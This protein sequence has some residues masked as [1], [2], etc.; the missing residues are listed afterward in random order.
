MEFLIDC[1]L[2]L[3]VFAIYIGCRLLFGKG[4][5]YALKD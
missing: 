2:G 4:N 3:G 1:A 5:R